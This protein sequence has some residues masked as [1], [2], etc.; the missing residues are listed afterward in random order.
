ME[1]ASKQKKINSKEG[2]QMLEKYNNMMKPVLEGTSPEGKVGTVGT[3]SSAAPSSRL[4][5]EDDTSTHVPDDDR[6]D[7]RRM[8]KDMARYRAGAYEKNAKMLS[9]M[10]GEHQAAVTNGQNI[11][12]KHAAE[13]DSLK[14]FF[15]ILN[16]RLQLLQA[17]SQDQSA[18]DQ[19]VE[20][21]QDKLS[22]QPVAEAQLK[23]TH[24][25]SCLQEKNKTVL[26]GAT[27]E[28][29]DTASTEV[30]NEMAI[31][32]QIR[33]S[34]KTSTRDIENAVKSKAKKQEAAAKKAAKQK[35]Q[36]KAKEEKTAAAAAAAQAANSSKQTSVTPTLLGTDLQK[37]AAPA[38][39][40]SSLSEFE[41]ASADF[42]LP[43]IIE[44]FEPL[45]KFLVECVPFKC[46]IV[47]FGNQFSSTAIAK[48]SGRA[49]CPV[50]SDELQRNVTTT[51]DKV[52]DKH[53]LVLPEDGSEAKI[54]KPCLHS[55]L[56]GFTPD[57][58]FSGF[59][60]KAFGQLRYVH[61]GVRKVFLVKL[62][63]FVDSIM[64]QPPANVADVM[65]AWKYV[66]L[67]DLEHKRV[68][69]KVVGLAQGPAS[70]LYVPP[71]WLI[72]EKAENGLAV[73]GVRR[74]VLVK[75]SSAEVAR[76]VKLMPEGKFSLA[77]VARVQ[78]TLLK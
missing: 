10:E 7:R 6:S 32:A 30:K 4:D 70:L 44:D 13:K 41:K 55:A 22:L 66:R 69:G 34:V 16:V 3:S 12:A 20:N 35:D 8:P 71:A 74:S 26:L 18:L 40:F 33:N 11:L 73:L 57:M 14:H 51:F 60:D 56:Y 39:K 27:K 23:N 37:V 46:Q 75:A 43:W 48:Q 63:D 19:C 52:L 67:E 17:L 31:H 21:I 72:A 59:E 24:V 58:E 47:N 65:Q 77:P 9:S 76:L 78:L 62:T 5:G 15:E 68:E 54:L 28:D 64:S 25:I 53:Q 1:L 50:Q 45:R 49:Q 29:V 42:D 36:E 38:Q 61:S 2:A